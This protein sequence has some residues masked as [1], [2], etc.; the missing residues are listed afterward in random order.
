MGRWYSPL[1]KW[2]TLEL[3]DS[4]QLCIQTLNEKKNREKDESSAI[5][6]PDKVKARTGSG[7]ATRQKVLL[8]P[9]DIRNLENGGVTS[10]GEPWRETLWS[11]A[12]PA[13][14]ERRKD[15]HGS[16]ISSAYSAVGEDSGGS[17]LEDEEDEDEVYEPESSCSE[18]SGLPAEED[19][20]PSRKIKFST[21]PIKV[22]PGYQ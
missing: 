19:P 18:I 17:Q 1:L 10:N 14:E 15:G 11:L 4:T 22:S 6:T 13:L 7:Q 9:A 8:I 2:S 20:P 21:S 12:S 16:S 3:Q 5:K